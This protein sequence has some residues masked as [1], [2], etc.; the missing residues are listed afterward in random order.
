[1]AT[2]VTT[3]PII[4]E[5]VKPSVSAYEQSSE[6]SFREI[7]A[8]LSV[9]K[10]IIGWV[11]LLAIST[12]SAIAFLI[13]AE[14]TAESVILTPQQA[15]PSLSTMV[16]LAGGAASLSGLSLLSG[17]G[18]RSPSDLYVGILESRTI[19]D[20]LINRFKLKQ[21][22]GD[23]YIQQARKHLSRRTSIKAGKDTL[24]RIEVNDRDPKRA[25]QLANAYVEE[26]ADRN[27]TVALTEASQRRLFFEQ[28][29]A[30]E[31]KLLAAAE[32]ALRDT[33][34]VTGLVVPSGQAEALIR[35]ASQLNAEILSREAMLAGMRTYASDE[36]PRF[37]AVQ[38][39][40]SALRSELSKLE[41]ERQVAGT[42][43]IPVGNLPQAGLEYVRKYRD[44]RYHEGL[45]EALAKQYEAARLDEA[46][47][48]PLIQVVD[49]AVVPERK[50]WPPR[51]LIVLISA[52]LSVVVAA[53]WIVARD[54]GA[55]RASA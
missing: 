43:E 1:M 17:L 18:L 20:A 10:R 47:A 34:K 12:S 53:L 29:L 5:Q 22:Y 45:Y 19:A 7:C 11:L 44:V 31:K 42:P 37:Q 16:Q 25:A 8:I 35:S 28:Q 9:R 13:P 6:I 23:K 36:N 32:I 51:L 24:I 40:L 39:E 14:Y 49:K 55:S 15:E 52:A 26:L 21:I 38:R 30:S 48:A 46:K 41:S 2:G 50:S 3:E 4:A 33:E 27:T 54:N